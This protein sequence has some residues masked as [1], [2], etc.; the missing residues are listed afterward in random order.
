MA[1]LLAE[2][3]SGAGCQARSDGRGSVGNQHICSDGPVFLYD[4]IRTFLGTF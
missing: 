1:T 2:E 4:R 3:S